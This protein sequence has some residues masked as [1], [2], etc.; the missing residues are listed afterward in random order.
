[1]AIKWDDTQT[2]TQA[3]DKMYNI[4]LFDKKQMMEWDDKDNFNKTWGAC[5]ML[6]KKY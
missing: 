1:M 6:F 3:I 5:N 2:F 4:S